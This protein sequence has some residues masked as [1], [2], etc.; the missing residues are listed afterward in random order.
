[1]AKTCLSIGAALLLAL[2][3]AETPS[4]TA[5]NVGAARGFAGRPV[6]SAA[7]ASPL[8]APLPSHFMKSKEDREF[9]EWVRKKKIASGKTRP[10]FCRHSAFAR[11]G[12]KEKR[13]SHIV[14]SRSRSCAGVDPDE[15]FATGR[16]QE[17]TI[18]L[19]GGG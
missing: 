1:M 14:F 5:F 11:R 7:A 2:L 6:A 13:R 17:S 18:Y 19:V 12:K 10:A 4:C 3:S 16:R 15:D 9:E 8:R